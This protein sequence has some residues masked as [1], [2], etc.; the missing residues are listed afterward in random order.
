VKWLILLMAFAGCM[1]AKVAHW[2]ELSGGTFGVNGDGVAARVLVC[3]ALEGQDE[4]PGDC[5]EHEWQNTGPTG[6]FHFAA[7]ATWTQRQLM[8]FKERAQRFRYFVAACTRDGI[9]GVGVRDGDPEHEPP[10]I[11]IRLHHPADGDE[12]GGAMLQACSRGR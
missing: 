10:D 1:P 11:T 2:P 8:S 5:A 7:R 9:A 3:S 6:R 12:L 4:T